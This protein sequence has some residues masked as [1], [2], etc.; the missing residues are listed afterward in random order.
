MT[1]RVLPAALSAIVWSLLVVG[2]AGLSA[3]PVAKHMTI[4]T[5]N[6]ENLFDTR[7]DPA[8]DDATFLPR[9]AKDSAQHRAGCATIEV[10]RWR[11]QCLE[12]D[13]SEA[14]LA[15]K[16]R[17][18][19]EA[20]LANS[21][22]GKGPDIVVL[23]EVENRGVVERLRREHLADAGYGP[24]VLI[25]GRD[26]R[27]IDVAFLSKLPLIGAP[28]LH[29]VVFTDIPQKVRDDTRGIL[30]ATFEL[31]DGTPLTGFAVHFPAPFHPVDLRIQSYASLATRLA[32]LPA[33]RLAFAAGDFNTI[34]SERWVLDQHVATDWTIAHHAGCTG[35]RG[36]YYYA[37]DDNWSF[38][39]MV[40]FSPSVQSGSWRLAP[41]RTG[42]ANA[43]PEQVTAAGTPK[44][45]DP[46]S[47]R[48]VSDHWPLIT[49]LVRSPPE[50]PN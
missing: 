28:R 49:T 38:L 34:L 15:G 21:P 37:P 9:T 40:L 8:T 41:D 29:E 46:A 26:R 10:P 24:V 18:V 5:F 45:F 47:G 13:W 23:Q 50:G 20:I 42:V 22:D 4:M 27:G 16:L 19:G 48:G 43:S 33:G 35:C 39:D 6:V 44:R 2:C 1:V 36:T 17:R 30:E 32:A 25:E 3:P 12:F 31:P 14:V 11:A 7:D